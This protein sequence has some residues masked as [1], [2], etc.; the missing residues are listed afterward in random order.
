MREEGWLTSSL[1]HLYGIFL[2]LLGHL[3][4]DYLDCVR[5]SD[6]SGLRHHPLVV[7]HSL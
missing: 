3:T 6:H 4:K 2:C 7:G 1:A 5:A